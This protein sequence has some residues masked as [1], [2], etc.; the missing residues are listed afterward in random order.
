MD[1]EIIEQLQNYFQVQ[2][3]P[4]PLESYPGMGW[5]L[6]EIS[7]LPP[8]DEFELI[9]SD[10]IRDNIVDVS[11]G[12]VLHYTECNSDHRVPSHIKKKLENIREQKFYV[13]VYPGNPMLY[14]GQPLAISIEPKI[15]YSEF[16]NHPHLNVG[17]VGKRIN[18][19]GKPLFIPDSFCY[20]DNPNELGTDTFQRLLTAFSKISVWLLRHMIWIETKKWIGLEAS[21]TI[22]PKDYSTLLNPTGLCR[23]GKNELYMNCHMLLDIEIKDKYLKPNEITKYKKQFILNQLKMWNSYVGIPKERVLNEFKKGMNIKIPS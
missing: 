17:D 19:N 7:P 10:I 1:R 13:A 21:S 22:T 4:S 9:V 2:W 5:F 8:L 23:C 14:S 11:L 3:F 16:P 18:F 6:L 20:T 15:S 12:K